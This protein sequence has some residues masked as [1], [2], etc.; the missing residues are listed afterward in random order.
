MACVQCERGSDRIEEGDLT[1]LQDR[2][3]HVK[4]KRSLPTVDGIHDPDPAGQQLATAVFHGEQL[5][6]GVRGAKD[7][8]LSRR[9]V[10][11]CRHAIQ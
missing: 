8:T 2:R 5:A 10:S 4:V 9:A 1:L 6:T 3:R 7:G 11:Y